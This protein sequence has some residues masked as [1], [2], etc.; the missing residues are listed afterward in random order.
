MRK[1][2]QSRLATRV[3]THAA[4]VVSTLLVLATPASCL[5]ADNARPGPEA[6]ADT[7][8]EPRISPSSSDGGR[9]VQSPTCARKSPVGRTAP[10]VNIMCWAIM[11]E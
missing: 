7:A 2:K 4:I 9:P 5:A 10:A 3:A 11:A 6:R 1:P 8:A